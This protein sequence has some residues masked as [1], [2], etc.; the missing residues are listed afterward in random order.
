LRFAINSESANCKERPRA[1]VKVEIARVGVPILIICLALS[2]APRCQESSTFVMNHNRAAKQTLPLL[3]RKQAYE[4]ALRTCPN[5]PKLYAEI[6]SFLI[7]SREFSSALK[8]VD[9]GLTVAPTDPELMLQSGAALLSLGRAEE[10]LVVLRNVPPTGKSQFYRG[11]AYR[12]L[13]DHVAA[14]DAL[15]KAWQLGYQDPYVLYSL[16]EEDHALG[17]KLAGMQ[18]FQLF[19]QRFPSSAWMHLLLGDAYS[20]KGHDD[21][22]RREYRQAAKINP[23]LL[24]AHYRLG[25]LAFKAGDDKQA[26]TE[27]SKELGL[28]P[29][30]A[31]AHLFL[32]ETLLRLGRTQ[33]A[34]KHLQKAVE[35]NG[36]SDLAYHRL[37]AVLTQTHQ[38]SEAAETLRRGE[39]KFP[40]DPMFPAQM[41][42]LLRRLGRAEEASQ[43]AERAR[44]LYARKL[45][46]QSPKEMQ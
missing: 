24:E 19:L 37:A 9:K 45:R 14:R 40:N 20:V 35:L 22:A 39:K 23:D 18:H 7:A 4:Q 28:D 32:G 34:L 13:S 27:F 33:A 36:S 11:M 5:D 3:E 1:R 25:Y 41:A 15:S 21:D 16:I 29:N 17:D 26:V 31:D 12:A 10:S 2:G 46:Q 6:G 43:A 42:T 38:L 30:F 8:W 44:E